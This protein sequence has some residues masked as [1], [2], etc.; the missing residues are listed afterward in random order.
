MPAKRK[1]S[2]KDSTA[3]LGFEANYAGD[4]SEA[5]RAA[6]DPEECVRQAIGNDEY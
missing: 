6:I 4:L 1:A 5:S 2:T 3:N